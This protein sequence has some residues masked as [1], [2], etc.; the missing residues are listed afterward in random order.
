MA[1]VGIMASEEAGE[2]PRAYVV[3]RP[4]QADSVTDEDIASHLKGRLANYKEIAGGVRR[5]DVIPRNASGKILRKVLRELAKN[6]SAA[7]IEPRNEAASDD[8]QRGLLRR[9]W[10]WLNAYD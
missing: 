2:L 5:L 8:T 7:D 9:F 6:E 10:N 4:S 3:L 1:V